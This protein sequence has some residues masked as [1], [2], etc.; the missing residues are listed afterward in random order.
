MKFSTIALGAAAALPFVAAQVPYA[1]GA[2]AVDAEILQYALTLEHLEAKFYSEALGKFSDEDFKAAGYPAAVRQRIGEIAVEEAT[3]VTTLETVLSAGGVTPT[4]ICQ[5]KFPYTDI[6]SFLGLSRILENVG[7]GAYL[8]KSQFIN[9][10]EYL[11]AAASI[12]SVEARHQAVVSTFVGQDG[13]PGPFDTPLTGSE[14]FSLATPFIT[15]CPASNPALPFLSFPALTV[16][17]EAPAAGQSVSF[18]LPAEASGDVF[19]HFYNGLSDIAVKL[20]NGSAT[21]PE[22]LTGTVYAVAS[23]SDARPNDTTTLAG[24]AIIQLENPD[25]TYAES[26]KVRRAIE[27]AA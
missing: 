16:A 6:P 14:V 10:K 22:G 5:Y 27:F 7:V 25:A 1:T 20:E 8:Y 17:T 13:I 18:T 23:T 26:K 9:N 24:P 21:L 19:I 12:L 4:E 15:S 3:H 11:I 2:A